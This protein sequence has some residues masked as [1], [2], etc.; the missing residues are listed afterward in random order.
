MLVLLPSPFSLSVWVGQCTPMPH[1]NRASD[2]ANQRR[3]G[4]DSKFKGLSKIRLPSLILSS[5]EKSAVLATRG[6]ASLAPCRIRPAGCTSLL[7]VR[8]SEELG[9]AGGGAHLLA[10]ETVLRFWFLLSLLAASEGSLLEPLHRSCAPPPSPV[11]KKSL[12]KTLEEAGCE[13]PLSSALIGS[14]VRSFSMNVRYDQ[15]ASRRQQPQI[16]MP[17]RPFTM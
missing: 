6:K 10:E 13:T 1:P 15:L 12:V 2:A 3:Y 17:M 11:S 9:S 5:V 7:A 4:L 8:L 16:L 14:P